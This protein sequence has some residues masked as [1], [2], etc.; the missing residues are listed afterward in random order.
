MFSK[1]LKQHALHIC[2]R[3][4]I[5]YNNYI[6]KKSSIAETQGTMT[7][8]NEVRNLNKNSQRIKVSQLKKKVLHKL[9]SMRFFRVSIY[10]NYT[11]IQQT[12]YMYLYAY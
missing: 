12:I 10:N 7:I 9:H 4:L 6:I 2:I 3:I 5:D 11:M 1:G 8:S